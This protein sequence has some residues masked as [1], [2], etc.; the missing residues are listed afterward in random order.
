MFEA[1]ILGKSK[2]S[3]KLEKCRKQFHLFYTFPGHVF[4]IT[5]VRNLRILITKKNDSA[6]SHHKM[7]FS[8]PVLIKRNTH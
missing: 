5:C 2:V 8:L 7:I 3:Q 6:G 1:V 4:Y